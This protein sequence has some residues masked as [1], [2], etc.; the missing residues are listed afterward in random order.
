MTK[1]GLMPDINPVTSVI[2]RSFGAATPRIEF[3]IDLFKQILIQWIVD[4]HISFCHGAWRSSL[5]NKPRG[6]GQ[7]RT[8][9]GL[10]RYNT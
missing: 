7:S 9:T 3:N 5:G 6:H 10:A 2:A 1:D 4:C 8:G